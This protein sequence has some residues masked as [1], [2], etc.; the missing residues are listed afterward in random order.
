MATTGRGCANR[1]NGRPSYI[2]LVSDADTFTNA[3]NVQRVVDEG[4]SPWDFHIMPP[5]K[6]RLLRIKLKG[7]HRKDGRDD[8]GTI[9]VTVTN[10]N[11]D[12]P[13]PVGYVDDP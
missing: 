2:A 9:T 3:T 11:M 6:P 13:V 4:G 8:T 12:V 10:P 1:S 5:V 7:Q